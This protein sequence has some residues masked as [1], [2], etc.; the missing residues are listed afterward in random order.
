LV[1]PIANCQLLIAIC[2][3]PMMIHLPESASNL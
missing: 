1:L 2:L 3:C